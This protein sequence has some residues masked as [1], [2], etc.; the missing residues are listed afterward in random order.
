M[1]FSQEIRGKSFRRK[2]LIEM[3][4]ILKYKCSQILNV[5][6]LEPESSWVKQD[7]EINMELFCKDELRLIEKGYKN[8]PI[9]SVKY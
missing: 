3:N 9:S 4:N 5:I 6:Y 7:S 2:K 8:S 1:S